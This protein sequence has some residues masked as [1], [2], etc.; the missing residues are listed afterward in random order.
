MTAPIREESADLQAAKVALKQEMDKLSAYIMKS[1][2]HRVKLIKQGG[3]TESIRAEIAVSTSYGRFDL[4]SN[5]LSRMEKLVKLEKEIAAMETVDYGERF[6]KD[7][8]PSS[9]YT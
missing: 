3:F 2:R 9:S 4:V 5:L 1:A 7:L 6:G 8:P